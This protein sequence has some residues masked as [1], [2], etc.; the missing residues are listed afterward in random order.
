M[1]LFEDVGRKVEEFRQQ[2]RDAEDEEATYGCA[3]CKAALYADHDRCPE[4][5]SEN[6]VPLKNDED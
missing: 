4:C 1:S 2:V 3:D 6:V 5:G